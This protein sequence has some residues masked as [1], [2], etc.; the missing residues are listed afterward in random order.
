[1]AEPSPTATGIFRASGNQIL[2]C[3]AVKQEAKFFFKPESEILISGMGPSNAEKTLKRVLE[4][5]RHSLVLSCGFAG[6]LNPALTVG[7]VLFDADEAT[8]LSSPLHSAGA[9]PGKFHFSDRVAI[10]AAEKKALREK[11]GADAVEMESQVIRSI[12]KNIGI[13][14]ATVR[15][16][17]DAADENLPLDFNALMSAENRLSY[18]RL[19]WTILNSPG[20]IPGLLRLERQT[21]MAAQ[22]LAE[23]LGR[24]IPAPS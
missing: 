19:F 14:S 10:T 18:G 13:P 17:S 15:V 23:V 22:K 21:K 4:K 6:A 16:I 3:F 5:K 8:G 7:T 9:R 20:A 11:T 1:M 24:I 12:C 2:V